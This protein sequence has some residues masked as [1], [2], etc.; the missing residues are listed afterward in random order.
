MDV[1]ARAVGQQMSEM[2]GQP[3]VVEN[4]AGADGLIGI[5]YVKTQP[6]DG[7]TVLISANTV[8]QLPAFKS[9]SGYD[10]SR[11]FTAVGMIIRAPYL[12][13]G[14]PSQSAKTLAEFIAAAKAKPD[15]LGVASAGVGTSTHM[16]A[17]LFMQQAGIHLLHVPYK[18][19]AAAMP[20]VI[21]GRVNV[22]FDGGNTSGPAIKDGQLR[23]FGITSPKRSP[24]FPNIPTLA[25]QGLPNYSF[26]GYH[27]MLVRAG[28]PKDVVQRLSRALQLAMETDSVRTRL[29]LDGSEAW[30]LTPE[31][32]N[33]F[34]HKDA[35]QT[36]KVVTD[37][38]LPT[39]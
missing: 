21:G 2:L 13:V 37:L 27:T 7:Y 26:Y 23:A 31:Q 9:D 11:D 28:T 32:T 3:I 33:D 25:E 17:A 22:I 10:V 1:T 12:M 4:R 38:G 8:A 34:L 39:E 16:A 20:D 30:P 36:A 29:R 18:G 35:Q 24:A 19:N 15:S 14:P 5:R 6:A